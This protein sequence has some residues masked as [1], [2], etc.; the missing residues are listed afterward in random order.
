MTLTNFPNG[1]SSFGVPVLGGL[2][3]PF[4]GNYYF[5]DAI[6]GADGNEGS[7]DS[8]LATL[9]T[10]Y[11]RCTSGNNDVVF[12]VGN[13]LATGTQRISAQIAWAK[14]AT[15]LIGITA[16][17]GINNRARISHA[18][19]APATAFTPMVLVTGSGCYFANFS[20]FE[21]FAEATA[22]VT[23]E[24][25]G[26][27]NCY[28]GVSIQ[29]MGNAGFSD[30]AAGSADLLLTGGGEHL[31][32]GCTIGLDTVARGAANANVRFRSQVARVTF[33]NCTFL[34]DA[35]AATP[36]FIDANAANSLNR[37]A[38]FKNCDFLNGLNYG[39]ATVLTAAVSFSAS[40]NGTIFLNKC[41]KAGTT[42][43]T[44]TDTGTV[45]LGNMPATS[46]DTGG[47]YVTSD[48]T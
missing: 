47:E 18:S 12:L 38:M 13:G 37:W 23:W 10:A 26:N 29:G 43:W 4:T 34:C 46:G 14:N 1:L 31:F 33:D 2:P 27:R 24:D 35:G 32:Q 6:S 41:S 3:I 17:N 20:I 16:P 42:D 25:Q 5:V 19:T 15:H 48:A 22:V 28:S 7:A 45:R 36:L 39:G 44:A 9:A 21:G 30:D 40:Q 11:G 8:P